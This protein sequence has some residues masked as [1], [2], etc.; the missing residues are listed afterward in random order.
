MREPATPRSA[1]GRWPQGSRSGK[2]S[3]EA[4]SGGRP[5]G[6]RR[7]SATVTAATPRNPPA[8][9]PA[10]P[11]SVSTEP[12][13]E[14]TSRTASRTPSASGTR[15]ASPIHA[16]RSRDGRSNPSALTAMRARCHSTDPRHL[17]D[18]MP[19]PRRRT[20]PGRTGRPRRWPRTRPAQAT[21]PQPARTQPRQG[22]HGTAILHPAG[23]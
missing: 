4:K 11:P 19:A 13:G 3:L 10:S 6:C 9:E 15:P 7:R 16:G 5:R 2:G 20:P 12:A 8:R 18:P 22:V 23:R 17:P 21:Q 1:P 14:R